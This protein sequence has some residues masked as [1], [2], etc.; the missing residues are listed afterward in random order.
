MFGA[1]VT[2]ARCADIKCEMFDPE[3]EARHPD[4]TRGED[5]AFSIENYFTRV[6]VDAQTTPSYPTIPDTV[7]TDGTSQNQ[8]YILER[9]R[10][11]SS[12]RTRRC[13]RACPRS[14]ARTAICGVWCWPRGACAR[15]SRT[16]MS[17][18]LKT[19]GGWRTS[20]INGRSWA[21]FARC[22]L[23]DLSGSS[24]RTARRP[25]ELGNYN[26]LWVIR[27]PG[28]DACTRTARW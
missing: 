24:G 25:V 20:A 10:S 11:R 17:S 19:P 28:R 5:C 3:A 1:F 14:C 22:G 15:R 4:H 6:N 7:T 13:S 9:S 27:H 16:M 2:C 21:I 12:R 18:T 26:S 23:I 8:T